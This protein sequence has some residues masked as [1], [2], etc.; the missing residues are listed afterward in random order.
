MTARQPITKH[1]R[2][3]TPG[4]AD[5]LDWLNRVHVMDTAANKPAAGPRNK[6][7]LYFETDTETLWESNGTTW[8]Q[9]SDVSFTTDGIKFNFDNEGG[10]LDV[11]TNNTD[12]AGLGMFLADA[13]GG[14]ITIQSHEGGDITLDSQGTPDAQIA[15]NANDGISLNDTSA[16]GIFEWENGSGGIHLLN[17]GDGESLYETTGDGGVRVSNSGDGNTT[18]ENTGNGQIL[19]D[20][21]TNTVPITIQTGTTIGG[22]AFANMLTLNGD[23]DTTLYAAS[24]QVHVVASASNTLGIQNGVLIEP[25]IRLVAVTTVP[26]ASVGNGQCVLYMFDDGLGSGASSYSLRVKFGGSGHVHILQTD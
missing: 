24:G 26:N 15:L 12:G 1:G 16:N 18:I 6:G 17:S 14:G 3:H 22:G 10:Y 9:I 7:A 19:V 2:D 23:A 8:T 5:E 13:S 4:A 11:T 21:T 20:G 25:Y